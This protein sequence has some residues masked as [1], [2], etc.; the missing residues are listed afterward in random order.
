MIASENW[1]RE[2]AFARHFV[3]SRSIDQTLPEWASRDWFWRDY[4]SL[5]PLSYMLH[6]GAS[7]IFESVE[8]ILLGKLLA[9]VQVAVAVLVAAIFLHGCSGSPPRWSASLS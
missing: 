4:I 9:Q 7:R 8:P 2:G 6:Y 5:P 1:R 3:P